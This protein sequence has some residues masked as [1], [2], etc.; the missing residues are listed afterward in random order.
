MIGPLNNDRASLGAPLLTL[1]KVLVDGIEP[2]PLKAQLP[3]H[4]SGEQSLSLLRRY[5]DQLGD[6]SDTTAILRQLQRFR[7]KGGIAHLA[8][9]SAK[10][11]RTELGIDSM[12]NLEA[13]ESIATRVT[14][15][16]TQ[17]AELMTS[18]KEHQ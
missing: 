5:A 13:F 2:A 7:S 17:L 3:T 9:S 6:T 8:G 16:L 1:T 4:D 12:T 10:T 15:C 18:T 11:A 14:A